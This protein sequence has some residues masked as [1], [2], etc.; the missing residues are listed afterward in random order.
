M[1]EKWKDIVLKD[2]KPIYQI[3]NFGRVRNIKRD[4]IVK[5]G[6]NS[7]GY[8]QISLRTVNNKN[9]I[10]SIHRLVM[11]HFKPID[12]PDELVIN[13][14]DT[15]KQNNLV[16]NLEWCTQKYNVEH[17]FATGNREIGE[18]HPNAV[19]SDELI[20]EICKRLEKGKS[21]SKI[22]KDLDLPNHNKTKKLIGAIKAHDTRTDISTQYTWTKVKRQ[23]YSDEFIHTICRLIYEGYS[24][25]YIKTQVISE[26]DSNHKFMV[27]LNDIRAGRAWKKV[28]KQIHENDKERS[29]T[30]EIR[31]VK[32][33]R[34][35]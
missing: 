20:H 15:N 1:K 27:L 5:S 19:Y 31:K 29:T 7:H 12:N 34:V 26:C 33:R 28:I 24:N 3:S 4:S 25:E 8:V 6:V 9:K 32:V 11:L 16:S 17:S 23:K 14:K 30:R 35:S 22:I 18:N 21:V 13:H 2:I 10:I